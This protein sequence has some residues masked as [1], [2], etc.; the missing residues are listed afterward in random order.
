MIEKPGSRA[1]DV[2]LEDGVPMFEV[3]Q[4]VLDARVPRK[5]DGLGQVVQNGQGD[6][7]GG[8]QCDLPNAQR[9]H[10]GFP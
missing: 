6:G 2:P 1:Q 3:L 9:C 10:S 4:R 8:D 7:G 5:I